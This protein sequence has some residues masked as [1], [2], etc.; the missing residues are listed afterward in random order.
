M[1]AIEA[2]AEDSE[3]LAEESADEQEGE[4]G[5]EVEEAEEEEEGEDYSQV[6][7]LV[8]TGV[9]ILIGEIMVLNMSRK[10]R[11]KKLAKKNKK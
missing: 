9:C 7:L 1:A 6:V 8:S 3:A 10:D 4:E 5:E 11:K 2:E